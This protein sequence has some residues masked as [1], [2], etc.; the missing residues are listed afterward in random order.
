MNAMIRTALAPVLA[1][2]LLAACS[3]EP[4]ATTPEP[5]ASAPAPEPTPTEPTPTEES[6]PVDNE[7]LGEEIAQSDTTMKI[8]LHAAW[9][10]TPKSDRRQVCASWVI[11]PE[12]V[13]GIFDE[14]DPDVVD[15]F[16]E[17]VC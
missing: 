7:A 8:L 17:E 15:E 16:F 14:V 6:E 12:R 4:E 1:V 11:Q 10:D 5:S 2:G 9:D 13:H 3:T